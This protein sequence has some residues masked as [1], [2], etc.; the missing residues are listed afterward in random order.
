MNQL[1]RTKLDIEI[2]RGQ[3]RTAEELIGDVQERL[4]LA[5]RIQ[6]ASISAHLD[7]LVADLRELELTL[8]VLECRKARLE[9]NTQ[10]DV[11]MIEQVI[12]D[13]P[14]NQP[15]PSARTFLLMG[16][17]RRV[18]GDCLINRV[19]TTDH[20]YETY[21]IHAEGLGDI[22]LQVSY[23]RFNMIDSG[24]VSWFPLHWKNEPPKPKDLQAY[25]REAYA[26]ANDLGIDS[27]AVHAD[28]KPAFGVISSKHMT[29]G[30]MRRV[31]DCYRAAQNLV[32]G[33]NNVWPQ[34]GQA[35]L[36][37]LAENKGVELH[38]LHRLQPTDFNFQPSPHWIEH[39]LGL[40]AA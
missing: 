3:I 35:I 1:N 11:E 4:M 36:D 27:K 28:L 38:Q 20:T 21:R 22:Q 13:E 31:R 12:A 5:P 8:E 37:R 30:Q 9:G 6:H 17:M 25:R 23:D 24:V 15:L 18:C 19:Q 2:T 34:S 16:A 29:T 40:A 7:C 33:C 32:E 14:N 39:A 26:I 10:P